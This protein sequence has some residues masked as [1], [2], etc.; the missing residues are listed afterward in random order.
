[1]DQS[2]GFL[3]AE[4]LDYQ[5]RFQPRTSAPPNYPARAPAA[6]ADIYPNQQAYQRG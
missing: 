4:R 5:I 2:L 6:S 1:M 3:A